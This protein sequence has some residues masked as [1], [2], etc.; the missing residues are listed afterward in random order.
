MP[1][2]IMEMAMIRFVLHS[3]QQQ[4]LDPRALVTTMLQV[5]WTPIWKS[6]KHWHVHRENGEKLF[7]DWY[8]A[9]LRQIVK[10]FHSFSMA[11]TWSS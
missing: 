5:I 3:K 11:G 6:Y 4:R 8:M 10:L 1:K 7:H 2:L 9:F